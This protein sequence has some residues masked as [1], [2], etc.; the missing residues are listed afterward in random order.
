MTYFSSNSEQYPL[1][2]KVQSARMLFYGK[3]DCPLSERS[4]PTAS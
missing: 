4:R 3:A 2:S 1:L